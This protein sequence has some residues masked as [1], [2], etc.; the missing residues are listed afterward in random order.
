MR[1][2]SISRALART[3]AAAALAGA[4]TVPTLGS[5]PAFAASTAGSTVARPAASTP[6]IPYSWHY[7]GYYYST[8]GECQYAGQH[9]GYSWYCYHYGYYWYLYYWY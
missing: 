9:S 8:Y 5:T 6:V 4:V 2:P 7:S 3:T 1:K